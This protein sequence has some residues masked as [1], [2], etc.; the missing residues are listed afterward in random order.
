MA[1]KSITAFFTE[2]GFPLKSKMWSW[3]AQAEQRLLLRTKQKE[4]DFKARSIR[5][6]RSPAQL[7]AEAASNGKAERIG[8]VHG[9]W[10]GELAG[11]TVMVD[12]DEG[13]AR[14]YRDD[15][16]F[17]IAR[18]E[19]QADGSIVAVLNDPVRVKELAQHAAS[20]RTAGGAGPFPGAAS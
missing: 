14:G 19:A 13:N 18:V 11:Y 10:G 15:V 2:L 1:D 8:H 5:I 6:L 16:V 20:H 4:Y 7:Q 17:P 12:S 3:G 9:L